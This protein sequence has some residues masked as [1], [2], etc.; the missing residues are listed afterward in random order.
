MI[1]LLRIHLTLEG[2]QPYCVSVA[3]ICKTSEA[4]FG[5]LV[6]LILNEGFQE[7]TSRYDERVDVFGY[8]IQLHFLYRRT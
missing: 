8:L 4:P 1:H 7:S 3:C 2:N 5:N 6:S